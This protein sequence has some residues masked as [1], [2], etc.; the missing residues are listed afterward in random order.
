MPRKT[1]AVIVLMLLG[2]AVAGPSDLPPKL[3]KVALEL[4]QYRTEANPQ[5]RIMQLENLAPTRDPRVAVVLGE[6]MWANAPE[7]GDA[8]GLLGKY[9]VRGARFRSRKVVR[10]SAWWEANEVVLRY[11]AKLLPR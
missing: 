2:Q 3:D 10:V 6:A 7:S 5:K 11:R 1:F 4:R 9:F 8:I